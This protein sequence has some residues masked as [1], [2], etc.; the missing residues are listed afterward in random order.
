MYVVITVNA[1][2]STPPSNK[3]AAGRLADYAGTLARAIEKGEQFAVV[4]LQMRRLDLRQDA[5]E[6]TLDVRTL[7]LES[8]DAEMTLPLEKP[9]EP[10]LLVHH[11]ELQMKEAALSA[12]ATAARTLD[13]YRRV[14]I[15]GRALTPPVIPSRGKDGEDEDG[16]QTYGQNPSTGPQPTH[17]SGRQEKKVANSKKR[18]VPQWT[19]RW[20]SSARALVV[21]E[22]GRAIDIHTDGGH[23]IEA[24]LP[25]GVLPAD[26]SPLTDQQ[27]LA[28]LRELGAEFSRLIAGLQPSGSA[29]DSSEPG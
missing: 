1:D 8:W 22:S 17:P 16:D 19:T 21:D 12:G 5:A 13:L 3:I 25:D 29:D 28:V 27:R 10:D 26:G 20:F 24:D 18:P 14:L 4:T 6:Y 11:F 9:W 7:G 2:H 23:I 15:D